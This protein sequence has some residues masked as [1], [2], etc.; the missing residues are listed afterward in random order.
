MKT[1]L[2][3]LSL[4]STAFAN[5]DFVSSHELFALLPQEVENYNFCS[6]DGWICSQVKTKVSEK[7]YKVKCTEV[8]ERNHD[9]GEVRTGL[10]CSLIE[11]K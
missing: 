10:Y 6:E 2:L 7:S 5:I 11:T 8:Q 9:L 4:S 3:A 1:L